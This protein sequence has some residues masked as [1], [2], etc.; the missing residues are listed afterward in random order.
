MLLETRANVTARNFKMTS[1]TSREDQSQNKLGLLK[2]LCACT[3]TVKPPELVSYCA[4]VI[5]QLFHFKAD[6]LRKLHAEQQ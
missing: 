2:K 6:C 4:F 1:I 5:G 3:V